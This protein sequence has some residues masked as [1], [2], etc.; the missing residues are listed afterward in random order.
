LRR[1]LAVTACRDEACD[2]RGEAVQRHDGRLRAPAV[3]GD[4]HRL[5]A[6]PG[7]ELGHIAGLWPRGGLTMRRTP[8]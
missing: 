8:H 1:R 3:P 2:Q 5:F 6:G 7:E 4:P